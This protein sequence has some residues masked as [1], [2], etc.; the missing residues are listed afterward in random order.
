M[1]R[2]TAAADIDLRRAKTCIVRSDANVAHRG[3]YGT[4]TLTG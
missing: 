3:Q 4:G 1:S 2:T